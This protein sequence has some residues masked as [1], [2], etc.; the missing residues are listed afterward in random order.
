MHCSFTPTFFRV[1]L[2]EAQ[3]LVSAK[4]TMIGWN[5]LI[6]SVTLLQLKATHEF[7]LCL[8]LSSDHN[9]FPKLFKLFGHF[10]AQM[11]VRKVKS[12]MY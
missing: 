12:L 1:P 5:E 10:G 9:G 6:E 4:V 7:E 11:N 8:I 3:N 2:H